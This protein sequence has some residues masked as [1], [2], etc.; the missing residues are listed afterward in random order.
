MGFF[1]SKIFGVLFL[2]VGNLISVF[3]LVAALGVT[4]GSKRIRTI[5][6]SG[7]VGLGLFLF[8][9]ALL[10]VGAIALRPLENRAAG[11]APAKVDGLVLISGD[12][13]PSIADSR[14]GEP[15]LGS[16]AG[17]YIKMAALARAY[18]EAKLV[19]S[20]GSGFLN[21][22]AAQK[23]GAQ[24]RAVLASLGVD[25]A[26]LAVEDASRTTYE[27]A[28]NAKNLAQ[29]TEGQNWLLVTSAA[30][31]KRALATFRHQGW[32]IYPAPTDY[33]TTSS[34]GWGVDLAL[35]RHLADLTVALHEYLGLLAYWIEGRI[36]RPW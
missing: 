36:D 32:N 6:R 28:V 27:N 9:C 25:P 29:P 4:D 11:V 23:N 16:V 15:A 18:P 10:P 20:G 34:L 7:L 2:D 5:A 21:E 17:R 12:E 22:D 19:F 33:R 30:H 1:L 24:A 14:A 26:R 35:T 31:M 8:L 13:R 3:A